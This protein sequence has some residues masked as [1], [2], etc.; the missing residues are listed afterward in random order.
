MDQMHK[1]LIV[2]PIVGTQLLMSAAGQRSDLWNGPENSREN[3]LGNAPLSTRLTGR[4]LEVPTGR[5]LMM[6]WI[7]MRHHAIEGLAVIV[8]R[9]LQWASLTPQELQES[10]ATGPLRVLHPSLHPE[11]R[12]RPTR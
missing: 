1:L 4:Q 3:P 2:L 5:S 6:W 11:R 12:L 9:Y 10:L 7:W 8:P